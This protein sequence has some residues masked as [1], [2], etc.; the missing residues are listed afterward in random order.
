MG[1]ILLVVSMLL[2]AGSAFASVIE[3][4]FLVCQTEDK[5]SWVQLSL[6]KENN[7]FDIQAAALTSSP[8]TASLQYWSVGKI[9]K[10]DASRIKA[11]FTKS[12][13]VEKN[14]PLEVTAYT[15]TRVTSYNL[16]TTTEGEVVAIIA[17]YYS[18]T[19]KNYVQL[20]NC[21]LPKK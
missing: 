16:T 4:P 17:G 14:L 3:T 5:K 6:I 9:T 7:Q 11:T 8:L 21:A 20:V 10:Q 18:E 2:T 13:I 19:L 1:K 12:G 15:P